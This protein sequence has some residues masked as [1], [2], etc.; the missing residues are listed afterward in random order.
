M[1]IGIEEKA[2]MI[3]E[4]LSCHLSD[5]QVDYECWRGE[6]KFVITRAGAR[7][8]VRLAEHKLL[9]KSVD[10]LQAL[11]HEVVKQ[12]RLSSDPGQTSVGV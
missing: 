2:C 11:V 8:K 6:H 7:F 12:V 10:E 5:G 9:R 1:T 4:G 3:L